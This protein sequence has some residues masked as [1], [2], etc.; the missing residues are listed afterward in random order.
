MAKRTFEPG[1]PMDLANMRQ[2]GV[3]RLIAYCLNDSCRHQ[4]LIDVS[5]YPGDTPVPWFA[6]KVVC[7]KCGARGRRI[8]VRLNW[9]EAPGT[10]TD[11]RGRP[12]MPSGEE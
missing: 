6:G 5:S 1:P 3:H 11:W 2:Q 10:I 4:A 8:D 12:A 7:N 9:K